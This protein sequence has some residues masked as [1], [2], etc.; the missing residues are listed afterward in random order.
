LFFGILNLAGA[1]YMYLLL[2]AC[3]ASS[4]AAPV[5]SRR[6]PPLFLFVV[7]YS[8]FLIPGDSGFGE[9]TRGAWRLALK[10]KE[11][12]SESDVYLADSHSFFLMAFVC[13]SRLVAIY[14]IY[15]AFIFWRPSEGWQIKNKEG[16][17]R[18]SAPARKQ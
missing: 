13:V 4:L 3:C 6:S 16:N 5:S 2:V 17:R 15:A 8:L 1:L 10:K 18:T 7:P 11:T 9:Y 12:E 14:Q